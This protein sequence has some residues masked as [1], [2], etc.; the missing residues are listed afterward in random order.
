MSSTL[1]RVH[2]INK[3]GNVF[4]GSETRAI[5]LAQILRKHADVKLWATHPPDPRLLAIENITAIDPWRLAFPR[6]GTFVFVG[7]YFHIGHW[8]QLAD[9]SRKIMIVN[10]DDP[11]GVQAM[12]RKISGRGGASGCEIVYSSAKL[13][14]RFSQQ[15]TV[16]DSPINIEIFAPR[17][18]QPNETF[19]IG[20]LSRNYPYKFHQDDPALFRQMGD[21]GV[22][23]RLMGANCIADDLAGAT[24]IEIVENGA[25][26]APEFLQSL[27]CFIYRTSSSWLESYGRVVFEAMACGLPVLCGGSGGYADYIENGVNG[28]LFDTNEEAMGIVKKLRSD[29]SLRRKI[30]DAARKTMEKTY[31]SSYERRLVDFYVKERS[32]ADASRVPDESDFG[33]VGK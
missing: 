15:G 2:I 30:G 7:A 31:S 9:P 16:E 5:R 10:T 6:T 12:L 24:N 29:P 14:S 28:Y 18:K 25:V 27:D 11:T 21:D 3:F 17:E 32:A 4:G 33:T 19:T 23:L 1:R 26:T 8:F 13:K 22:Y 20:R